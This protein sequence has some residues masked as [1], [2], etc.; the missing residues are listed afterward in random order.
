MPDLS[1]R[2][3][4]E[5]TI[6]SGDGTSGTISITAVTT[7][8]TIV[9]TTQS[10]A[11]TQYRD[12]RH[13]LQIDL[14]ASDTITWSRDTSG[15]A[16]DIVLRWWIAESADFTVQR[17]DIT[18]IGATSLTTLADTTAAFHLCSHETAFNILYYDGGDAIRSEI[19]STTN[20]QTTSS[21]TPTAGFVHHY[22]VCELSASN[23]AVQ[24]GTIDIT[25]T[26]TTNTDTITSVDTGKT[27]VQMTGHIDGT[28]SGANPKK[29]SCMVYLTNATTV[30][31]ERGVQD[32]TSSTDT[33]GYEVIEFE[34]DTVVEYG[35]VTITDTNTS[36]T[37]STFS[38]KPDESKSIPMS[39]GPYIENVIND[40]S[41]ETPDAVAG[42]ITLDITAGEVD[43]V[44][45]T[46]NA[47]TS[48]SDYIY[49]VVEWA[50]TAG[51]GGLT[52]VNFQASH[53][54]VMR[55][56]ARGVG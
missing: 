26:T 14:T 7:G 19:T 1:D 39:N 11:D 29:N 34:D 5:V 54:G 2:Q 37:S 10:H 24:R 30:T 3:T 17:G 31:A 15:S 21:G 27:W 42:R 49:N 22:Q 4:G 45:V 13:L 43:S 46:R 8:E 47:S 28:G 35:E 36:V 6:T 56:V 41:G 16:T 40:S 52:D 12:F 25:T 20:L 55:G 18:T 51:G 33:Y 48:G 32:S 53:R 9:V 23:V 50:A 44:T 38:P